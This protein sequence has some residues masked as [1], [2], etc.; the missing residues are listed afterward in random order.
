MLSLFVAGIQA[1]DPFNRPSD[2]L[3]PL[4]DD[5]AENLRSEITLLFDTSTG[6]STQP[7]KYVYIYI[8][9]KYTTSNLV[10]EKKEDE[11]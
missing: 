5:E 9:I 3:R 6:S 2:G 11:L 4:R 8:Y 7:R 10:Y 1:L